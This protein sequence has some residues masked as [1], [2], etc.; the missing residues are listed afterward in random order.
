[1]RLTSGT[2]FLNNLTTST[3]PLQYDGLLLT[4]L[5]YILLA[6]VNSR[7]PF[8]PVHAENAAN[9]L[10]S[11]SEVPRTLPSPSATH[12]T[13]AQPALTSSTSLTAELS[14]ASKQ[15]WQSLPIPASACWAWRRWRWRRFRTRLQLYQRS[16]RADGFPSRSN[17][18]ESRARVYGAE[19]TFKKYATKGG[20]K[21]TANTI[22]LAEPLHLR[23]SLETLLQRL[24]LIRCSKTTDRPISLAPQAMDTT[25]STNDH[26]F[27]RCRRLHDPTNIFVQLSPST[28]R[29][30]LSRHVHPYDGTHN[31]HSSL[32]SVSGHPRFIPPRDSRQHYQHGS[33]H[34]HF[35]NHRPQA[36]NVHAQHQQ[37]LSI[38]RPGRL[39]RVQIRGRDSDVV[40]QRGFHR[41]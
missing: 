3:N 5:W 38:T 28:R 39:L 8:S 12:L 40:L 31:I 19:R 9:T 37:R 33:R 2:D 32:N 18:D 24:Q 15:L 21:T 13:S 11:A 20:P 6:V 35:R 14:A 7:P 17:G 16:N 41:G 23:P 26:L 1:M 30:Q 4:T 25:T 10:L 22:T 27:H 29:S 36:R 34:Y